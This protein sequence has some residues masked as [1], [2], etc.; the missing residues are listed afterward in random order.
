MP[1]LK[2]QNKEKA[3]ETMNLPVTTS[4]FTI[5]LNSFLLLKELSITKQK[6]QRENIQEHKII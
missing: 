2:E 6:N 3:A 5:L 1:V 4:I